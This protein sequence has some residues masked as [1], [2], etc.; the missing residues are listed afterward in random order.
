MIPEKLVTPVSPGLSTLDCAKAAELVV[1]IATKDASRE[2]VFFERDLFRLLLFLGALL[3][4]LFFMAVGDH[5]VE[6]S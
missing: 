2:I 4:S 1:A 6:V 5:F 3:I